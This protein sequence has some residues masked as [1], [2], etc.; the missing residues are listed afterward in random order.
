MTQNHNNGGFRRH[1]SSRPF[2][3][4]GGGFKNARPQRRG[5]RSEHIHE[6][7]FI[8][9]ASARQDDVAFVP[10]QKFSELPIHDAVKDS[11]HKRGYHTP[12]PIQDAAIPH[13]LLG[14]DVLGIA[15]TGTGK[16]G[17]FLIPLIDKI[18]KNNTERVLIIVPTR[19]L[20][21]Q[22]QSEFI[23][24]TKDLQLY[25]VCTV[26]G[27][28]MYKQLNELRRPH[29]VVIG[30]PGRLKDLVHRKAIR[31]DSF[32]TV[33]LDEADRM[34]DMGFIHDMRTVVAGMPAQKQALFFT[35]TL[36]NAIQKL[37]HEFLKD[38]IHISVK[39]R[40]TSKNVDQ[41]I[42]RVPQGA[43]KINVLYE[44]LLNQ[45]FSKVLIFGGT[46]H[47][48]ENLSR[49]LTKLGIAAEA[50]HGNKNH[51]QRQRALKR[52]KH[53]ETNVL[54]ATDVAARGL[55]ID[56]VTHVINYDLPTTYDDYVHRIGRTGRGEKQG[57]ALTFIEKR[58]PSNQRFGR[59]TQQKQGGRRDFKRYR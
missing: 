48:V 13:A 9:K 54:V 22:V 27:A 20:A 51:N 10:Q 59:N 49:S 18:H 55:D 31:L 24:L 42:V 12:T 43:Q 5:P 44:L 35:A 37:V 47:G 52:F 38:P 46:K 16:T 39:T 6:S 34:L 17:A 36:S 2:N 33:V 23:A 21:L 8:N 3:N 25:S 53:N 1:S 15:N 57:K 26:G 40:D 56:G 32:N 19:E 30:T 28:S 4:R 41:D 7:R 58:E 45:D 50:I 11:I 29:N 14:K